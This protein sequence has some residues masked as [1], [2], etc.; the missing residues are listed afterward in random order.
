VVT[1]T[2]PNGTGA[3]GTLLSPSKS[4]KRA[5]LKIKIPK[6]II[7]GNRNF[8]YY[9]IAKGFSYSKNDKLNLTKLV[10]KF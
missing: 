9:K 10:N 1:Q 3:Q 4:L 2:Q 6:E 8:Y 7:E 5:D